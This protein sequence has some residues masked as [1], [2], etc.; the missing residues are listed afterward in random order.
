MRLTE[1]EKAMLDGDMGEVKQQAL[2]ALCDLSEFYDV[3][4]FV[5]IVG[6]HDDSTVYAGEA[7]VAFA[8]QL[9]A[10]GAK[11][12]VP[13]TTNATA[14]DINRW[15]EQCHDVETM[16][17]TKRIEAAHIKMGAVPTWSCAPYHV[18]VSPSFG[19]QLACAE[20]NV[21]CY[22]NSIMAR[23]RIATPVR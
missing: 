10:K 14:C 5:E 16:S 12:A 15:S 13:T 23:G 7:Q 6:C 4:E 3:E 22:Y 9:A 21:I 18:G 20:S 2:Q 11:F 17:A 1:Y 8:E 19:Q